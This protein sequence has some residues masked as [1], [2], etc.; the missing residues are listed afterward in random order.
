MLSDESSDNDEPPREFVVS[1]DADS[2]V[3][4]NFSFF[5]NSNFDF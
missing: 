3:S 1:P 2:N 4:S 5:L